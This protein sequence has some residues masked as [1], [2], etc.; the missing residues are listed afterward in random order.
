MQKKCCA[1]RTGERGVFRAETLSPRATLNTAIPDK[2]EHPVCVII[3]S[4][5]GKQK[6]GG[7]LNYSQTLQAALDFIDGHITREINAAMI[8]EAAGYSVYHFSR[9]FTEVMGISVM[10]YVI[11][12]PLK[13]PDVQTYDKKGWYNE[14]K[15]QKRGTR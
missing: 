13:T 10:S 9:I 4:P 15:G 14:S 1:Q 6:G 12:Q 3:Q 7:L 8:A 5:Y 11:W 2:R